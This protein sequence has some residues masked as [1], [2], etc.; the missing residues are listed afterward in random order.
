MLSDVDRKVRA[1]GRRRVGIPRRM[2]EVAFACPFN[3]KAAFCV[4]W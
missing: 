3:R 4:L 2:A 1:T